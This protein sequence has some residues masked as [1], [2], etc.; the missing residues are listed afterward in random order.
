MQI[1]DYMQKLTSWDTFN[2]FEAAK[3]CGGQ[4]LTAVTL[5]SLEHFDLIEKLQLP[6]DKLFSFLTV[7]APG[8]T[9]P[10]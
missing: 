2:V 4:I 1:A 7:C 8:S 10:R 5:N 6:E 9:L 3:L